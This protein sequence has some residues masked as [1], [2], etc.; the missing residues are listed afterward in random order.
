MMGAMCALRGY[1]MYRNSRT[2][3][4]VDGDFEIRLYITTVFGQTLR[5]NV[6]NTF[7]GFVR[8]RHALSYP[9]LGLP[10]VT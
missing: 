1:G 8:L 2:E 5:K 10:V 4:K 9:E 6:N 3:W 7:P